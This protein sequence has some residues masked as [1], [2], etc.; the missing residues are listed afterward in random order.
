MLIS[1]SQNFVVKKSAGRRGAR[2]IGTEGSAEFDFYTA[3]IREDHY[4]TPQ[5]IT[6]KSVSYTHLDVYKRQSLF[7]RS[8]IISPPANR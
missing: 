1:Y 2:L 5:T 8:T 4:R 3:E 7:S 6:H